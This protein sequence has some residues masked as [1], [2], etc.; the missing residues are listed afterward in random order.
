MDIIDEISRRTEEWS[1][2]LEKK[3][4]FLSKHN[5][6]G[7]D[8]TGDYLDPEE[9]YQESDYTLS[10]D[11]IPFAPLGGLHALTGQSGHGKTMTITQLIAAILKGHCGKI[12][13]NLAE[14]IPQPKVL[15][16]DTEM[17]KINTQRVAR[18]VRALCGFPL[19][20]QRDDFLIL[21][22]RETTSAE[23]RW[24]KI[25][26][27]IYRNRPTVCFIDGLIDIVSDFNDNATC[28]ELIYECM[29]VASHYNMSL[30][31]LVHQNPGQSVKMVGHIGSML[32][33]KVTD[34]FSTVKEKN[35]D[36]GA[37]KFRVSQKKARGMDIPDWYFCVDR[38]A[39]HL[40]IPRQFSEPLQLS[41]EERETQE[42]LDLDKNIKSCFSHPQTGL[43][44]KT[45]LTL[46]LK[47]IYH[48]GRGK[49]EDLVAKALDHGIISE[50]QGKLRYL[51]L[52]TEQKDQIQQAEILYEKSDDKCPF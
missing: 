43:E 19:T 40:G 49:A 51:G 44:F 41:E 24:R 37:V 22:L 10:Y 3:P 27:S 36:T 50:E 34:I 18:R 42:L 5:W 6:Y 26:M 7:I 52:S 29:S 39:D 31:C 2:G 47:D 45:R 4:D 21:M 13:Y 38:D 20:E 33:R 48:I 46:K 11:G 17:E 15:Y 23:D 25:L 32:E 12:S 8:E 14:K 28:Q 30:W 35:D 9:E 1:E 16:I